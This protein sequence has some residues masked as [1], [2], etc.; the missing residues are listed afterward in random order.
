[1]Y[2]YLIR[3][4]DICVNKNYKKMKK[5]KESLSDEVKRLAEIIE[6]T[7]MSISE[8]AKFI[9]INVSVLHNTMNGRNNIS[10]AIIRSV[11]ENIPKLNPRWLM[12]GI[13]EKYININASDQHT[14]E[15]LEMK[16]QFLEGKI[17]DKEDIISTLKGIK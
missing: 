5:V 11:C 15:M 13:G 6:G 17:K 4:F 1:M 10:Y 8:Y 12:F 16:V 7:N 2:N 14:I 3:N 9:G